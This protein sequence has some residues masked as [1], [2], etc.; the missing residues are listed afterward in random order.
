MVGVKQAS[1]QIVYIPEN[2]D[3]NEIKKTEDTALIGICK[4][5]DRVIWDNAVHSL[6]QYNEHFSIS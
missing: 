1:P 4:K 6:K 5:Y 3:K 2:V